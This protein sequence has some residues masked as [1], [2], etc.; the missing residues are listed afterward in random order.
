MEYTILDMPL[1]CFMDKPTRPES[2][3]E[4]SAQLL[5]VALKQTLQSAKRNTLTVGALKLTFSGG[6]C[7]VNLGEKTWVY[8]DTTGT[9][10]RVQTEIGSHLSRVNVQSAEMKELLTLLYRR[11]KDCSNARRHD[12]RLNQFL[13]GDFL[14]MNDAELALWTR[15]LEALLGDDTA[16]NELVYFGEADVRPANP[17]KR[18]P[19]QPLEPEEAL[20]V[21]VRRP[22]APEELP[23]PTRLPPVRG[24]QPWSP[25]VAPKAPE[26]APKPSVQR[27]FSLAPE[28]GD[29]PRTA[30]FKQKAAAGEKAQ[31]AAEA[32]RQREAEEARR[33]RDAER[34]ASE[35]KERRRAAEQ[36]A[37]QAHG[38]AGQWRKLFNAGLVVAGLGG[39]LLTVAGG[40]AVTHP[41]EVKSALGLKQDQLVQPLSTMKLPEGISDT[42]ALLLAAAPVE[43][44]VLYEDSLLDRYGLMESL[45]DGKFL[46]LG[47]EEIQ[48]GEKMRGYRFAIPSVDNGEQEKG[49]VK[50]SFPDA[51][52]TLLRADLTDKNIKDWIVH[53]FHSAYKDQAGKP[54][55]LEREG[56]QIERNGKNEVTKVSYV[57]SNKTMK[58]RYEQARFDEKA[59][60][61]GVISRRTTAPMPRNFV[62]ADDELLLFTGGT[63][64]QQLLIPEKLL[65]ADGI[66]RLKAHGKTFEFT[67]KELAAGVRHYFEVKD[68][69]EHKTF[70]T[71]D[72]KSQVVD[73]WNR[74]TTPQDPILLRIVGEITE[75]KSEKKRFEAVRKAFQDT[76]YVRESRNTEA[77]RPPVATLLKKGGDCNNQA[78]KAASYLESA[79][80]D[81]AL[82]YA[83][84]SDAEAKVAEA[85]GDAF[86]YSTHV[87]VGVD[88]SDIDFDLAADAV[89]YVDASGTS[90]V[91]LETN[92]NFELGQ[93]P[94][95]DFHVVLA[96]PVR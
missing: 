52:N 41:E 54:L 6:M 48:Y 39:G 1:A 93:M 12:F 18:P 43:R 16:L 57:G 88:E 74:Y 92:G 94:L 9:L 38:H 70:V 13:A 63:P 17:A 69:E 79:G 40:V 15:N 65:K 14:N 58:V 71:P 55:L 42:G 30:F 24:A 83:M 96:D 76:P 78:V 90:W 36:S 73:T 21:R 95:S 89:K 5:F 62:G 22:A 32:A 10:I 33:R 26:P 67:W 82:L 75:G 77:N 28:E 44:G 46:V 2:G 61:S 11:A 81:A 60:K 72:G 66:G 86:A 19:I 34:R 47:A 87:L 49:E 7:H 8:T 59:P 37:Q 68:K 51:I 84:R 35:E 23:A 80:Y 56:I 85:N 20:T 50:A 53:W 25:P 31:K 3:V 45:F 91:V 4:K 64:S 27:P 29:G